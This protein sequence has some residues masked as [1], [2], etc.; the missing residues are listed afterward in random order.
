MKVKPTSRYRWFVV[1]I[2]FIF[3]LLHQS[4]KLL[5]GPLTSPIMET[6]GIDEVQMGAIFTGALLVGAIL[7]PVWGYLYDRFTRSKLLA[8]ASFIWGSTTWLSAIAPT[9]P[10]FLVTRASTGI[11]DSS[12]PGLYSLIADYFGPKMRGKIY[13]LLQLS[14]PLGYMVGLLAATLLSGLLGWQA[15]FY[16][17]GSLGII[18]A[19]V[20]YFGVKEPTRGQSEPE[21]TGLDEIVVYRFDLSTAKGLF[22]K[23]SLIMLFIQ[24]FLGLFPWNVIAYWFFRY[25][26]I[27]RGYT[28]DEVLLTMAPAIL[29]LAAGYFIGGALGDYFF[30]KTPRGRILVG[31]FGVISGAIFLT[32]ALLVPVENKNQFLVLMLFTAVFMPF[33]SANVIATVYDITLPE[34]RS[35]ALAIQFLIENGGAALAPLLAGLIA[36]TY[37]L[38]IAILSICLS[39]WIL[40]TIF[41][42]LTAYLVPTD[43]Q[44]LRSQMQ[45]RSE[46]ERLRTT[47]NKV[48]TV[49]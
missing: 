3:M 8:L 36:R 9:Y 29:V 45:E 2:F 27:E 31:M 43:I 1:A 34:V 38:H 25:L 12:Y 23:K 28:S 33:S 19:I 26:E 37:S 39:A 14:Q 47:N 40:A 32:L 44:T 24:G 7:Y 11:D 15:V 16:I 4:D 10:S 41:L 17:T 13:G 21:L 22:R 42:G 46:I 6:F 5:I 20:I 18:L 35:T 30:R 48:A 49:S